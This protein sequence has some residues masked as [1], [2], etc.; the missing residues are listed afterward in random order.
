M[1]SQSRTTRRPI[2]VSLVFFAVFLAL[3]MTTGIVL[4]MNYDVRTDDNTAADWVDVPVFVTDT[5]NTELP[6]D[7]DVVE[8]KVASSMLGPGNSINY[9]NFM[10]KLAGTTEGITNTNKQAVASLD[11]DNN[12]IDQEPHDLLVVYGRNQDTVW[13]LKG[14]KF[15]GASINGNQHGEAIGE[16]VEW[17]IVKD[18]LAPDPFLG[19]VDCRGQ[20]GIRLMTSTITGQF[21]WE[22]EAVD[23]TDMNGWDVPTAIDLQSFQVAGSAR[24][25]ESAGILAAGTTLAGLGVFAFT[26]RRKL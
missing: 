26:R 2:R 18:R 24:L 9:L 20:I 14:D 13:L 12:G 15:N 10:I 25:R 8:G 7:M 3:L 19:N 5:V 4:A 1:L 22:S 21:P 11:C 17:R 6:P 23:D 16:Y